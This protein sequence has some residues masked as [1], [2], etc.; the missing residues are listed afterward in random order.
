MSNDRIEPVRVDLSA[1]DPTADPV[2]WER[3]VGAIATRAAPE[4]A[5]RRALRS[6]VIVL[7]RWA[8][9]TLSAAAAVILAASITLAA[10][11][12]ASAAQQR[13]VPALAATLR[14][15]TP[16]ARWVVENRTPTA[17]DLVAAFAGRDR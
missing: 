15:P 13:A 12:K 9:P 4:L 6:P 1:L 16:V 10:V 17:T 3:L 14:V 11:A 5:R 2:R 8:R 7:A